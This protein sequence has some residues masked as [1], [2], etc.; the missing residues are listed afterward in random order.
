MNKRILHLAIPNIISN[1]S[2]PLL[3]LADLALM[4]HMGSLQDLGAI[5]LGGMIF[6]FIYWLFGFLRMGTTGFT[7]QSLGKRDLPQVVMHLSKAL[8]AAIGSA[9]LLL[10]FKSLISKLSFYIVDGSEQVEQLTSVYF[11]IRIWAAP[12][13]ISLYAITGWFIGMQNTRF[14]MIITIALNL[15]NIG[16]NVLFVFV[17]GMRSDGVALGTVLAQYCGLLLSLFFLFRYYGKLRKYFTFKGILNLKEF[18]KVNSN[19]FIRTLL[20]ILALSFFTVASAEQNDTIL[21]VNTLLLQFFTIFSYFLDG[22]AYSAEALTGKFLGANSITRLRRMI[23]IT[24]LWAGAL[25]IVFS[26]LYLGG[27]DLL[28]SALTN[29]HDVISAASPFL[30]WVIIIPLVTFPAFIWDGVYIGATASKQ[31]RNVMIIAT[32]VFFFPVFY[33]TKNSLGNHG[34]WLAFII[35]MLSRSV[36]MTLTAKKVIPD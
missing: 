18:F 1:L 13:T 14:P 2:V 31:M 9:L 7:A 33:L 11:N 30:P 5:A 26:L 22:F 28:L 16:F 4:G 35:M 29:K 23:K 27:N 17:F 10:L 24:F 20:L 36:L 15:L 12:A 3:G 8:L 21:A 19:L 32:V 34:L 25:S 6:N